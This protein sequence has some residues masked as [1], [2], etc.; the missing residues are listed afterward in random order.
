MDF[1]MP[2]KTISFIGAGKV[3]QV[4]GRLMAELSD[5]QIGGIYSRSIESAQKAHE[6]I[7]AG[8]VCSSISD[9]PRSDIIFINTLLEQ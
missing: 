2:Q 1:L 5:F 3:T 6:F 9:I 7:N 8:K 4:L